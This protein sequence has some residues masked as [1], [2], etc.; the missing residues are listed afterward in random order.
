[1]NKPTVPRILSNYERARNSLIHRA[2]VNAETLYTNASKEDQASAFT[3]EMIR[4]SEEEGLTN[5]GNLALFD[6]KNI[7]PFSVE[8]ATSA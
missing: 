6:N 5:E 1:M 4:L 8:M 2:L 3:R 7:A